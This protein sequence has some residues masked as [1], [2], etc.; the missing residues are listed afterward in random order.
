MRVA[1]SSRQVLQL[2][3]TLKVTLWLRVAWVVFPCDVEDTSSRTPKH[4][5]GVARKALSVESDGAVP[6][7][8][9]LFITP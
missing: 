2:R 8:L 4:T 9:Q 3:L 5:N 1:T 7:G 6:T